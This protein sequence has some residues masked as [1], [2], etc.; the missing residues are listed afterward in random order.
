MVTPKANEREP[1]MA[2]TRTDGMN[3]SLMNRD[4]SSDHKPGRGLPR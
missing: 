3:H 4:P 2:A 1:D